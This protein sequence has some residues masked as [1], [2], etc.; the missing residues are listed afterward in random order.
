V[1]AV[2]AL[3]ILRINGFTAF[4]LEDGV[5]ELRAKGFVL[6]ADRRERAPPPPPDDSSPPSP[7]T[8]PTPLTANK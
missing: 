1:L 5:D 6:E 2:E 7:P 8:S 4:A 3:E